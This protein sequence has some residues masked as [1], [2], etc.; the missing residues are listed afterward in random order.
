MNSANDSVRRRHVFFLSGFDPKGASYYHALYRTEAARQAVV[1]GMHIEVGARQRGQQG[2]HVWPIEGRQGGG[3][4]ETVCEFARWDDIVRQ[5]WPRSTWRLLSEMFQAYALMLRS[6]GVP[7]VWRMA[8]KTLIALAYPLLFMLTAALLSMAAGLGLAAIL[9]IASLEPA[10]A[11]GV[12]L[13]VT[14]AGLWAARKLEDRLN[15]TWLLR[16]FSFAGKQARAELPE[17][18]DRLDRFA[19]AIA[20]KVR[21]GD[22]DEVLVVGFSV[23]S[24]LAVSATA[25]AL[26]LLGSDPLPAPAPALSLLTLGHCIP[27]L[28][29]LPQAGAFRAELETLARHEALTWV[30]FSS[31]TDWGSFALVDPVAA[32]N[33]QGD[34]RRPGQPLMRSPRF[35]TMFEQSD[36]ARLIKNKRRMHLQYL[37]AGH[38]P[39]G[40]DYFAIT[41]GTQT[42]S[43][44]YGTIPSATP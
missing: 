44:R 16:I 14:G 19:Q 5:H 2:H 39:A 26:K 41:A 43:A 24:I 29:L 21:A 6:G 38:L 20:A 18:E 22:A 25:R 3:T 37:M 28:G 35:H 9:R 33:G 17:L 10:L 7:K 31:P 11:V 12:G 8:R 32:C 4:C 23:G 34:E 27:M 15:T 1:S 40:Y 42:L 13:A 30:D 36:Y